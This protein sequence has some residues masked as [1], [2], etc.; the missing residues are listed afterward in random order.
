MREVKK[1]RSE[2]PGPDGEG[3]GREEASGVAGESSD[4]EQTDRQHQPD[5]EGV[6]LVHVRGGNGVDVNVD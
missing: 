4:T 6:D 5:E 3:G 2:G 1:E